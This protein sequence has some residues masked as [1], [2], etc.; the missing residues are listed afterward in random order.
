[1][2]AVLLNICANVPIH[3]LGKYARVWL[4]PAPDVK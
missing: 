2:L 1:V 3:V 4:V